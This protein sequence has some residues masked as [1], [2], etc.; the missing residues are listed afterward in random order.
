MEFIA[1]PPL[2][3]L[4]YYLLI[5]LAHHRVTGHKKIGHG[6]AMLWVL[7]TICLCIILCRAHQKCPTWYCHHLQR[8]SN[9]HLKTLLLAHPEA[10][11]DAKRCEEDLPYLSPLE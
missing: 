7:I 2:K 10:C 6:D 11:Q 3:A 9:V 1:L 8:L 4:P 5:L